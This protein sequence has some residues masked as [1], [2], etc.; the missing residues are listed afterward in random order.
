VNT[1][2]LI[3][4]WMS[5]VSLSALGLAAVTLL[6]GICHPIKSSRGDKLVSAGAWSALVIVAVYLIYAAT[7][8]T[9]VVVMRS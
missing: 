9:T 2:Q 7:A 1:L 5:G 4:W 8:I 6:V 3:H